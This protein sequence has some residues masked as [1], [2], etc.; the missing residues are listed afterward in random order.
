MRSPLLTI[1]IKELKDLLRDPRVFIGIFVI[2]LVIF[3][4]MGGSISAAQTATYEALKT[5]KVACLN[6][7]QSS[8]SYEL[9]EYLNSSK[10][11]NLTVIKASTVEEAV[12]KAG[13][14]EI[15]AL[16]VIP[17]GFSQNLS[18]YTPATVTIIQILKKFSFMETAA[19]TRIEHLVEQFSE[20]VSSKLIKQASPGINPQAVLNPISASEKTWVKGALIKVSPE[21]LMGI[22][23]SQSIMLPVI[24]MVL[25]IV[26]AQIAATSVAMEK[27]EKTLETLL[28]IPVSRFTILAGKLLGS[29]TI[30]GLGAIVYTVGFIVYMNAVLGPL[31]G[32]VKAPIGITPLGYTIIGVT[33]FLT[34]LAALAIAITISV[35]AEDVRGAQSLLGF[36]LILVI[37]PFLVLMM[38]DFEYFPLGLK[39]ALFAIP[40]SHPILVAKAVIAEDYVLAIYSIT[41]ITAFTLAILYTAA[42]FFTTE[43]IIT[44]KLAF[45]RR[46]SR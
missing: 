8:W 19:S 13:S 6:L 3:P 16:L 22:I 29:T 20:Q 11:I 36:I 32:A 39:I 43:K 31:M 26:A 27:E 45:K 30:A 12:E 38:G 17:E 15:P 1:V 35:F 34:L 33:I 41:Y 25:I 28:T 10:H 5:V 42:K 18:S 21:Q 9:I 46:I 2:P 44:A 4:V 23:M 40:F 24:I 37:I 14:L 7:D